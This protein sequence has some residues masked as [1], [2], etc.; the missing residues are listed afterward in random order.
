MELADC[1]GIPDSLVG[2]GDSLEAAELLFDEQIDPAA[3]AVN[4]R[5]GYYDCWRSFVSYAFLHDALD[6]ALVRSPC[7]FTRRSTVIARTARRFRS[8]VGA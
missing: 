8:R 5:Q 3:Q 1:R 7:T 6:Q 2:A 4:T